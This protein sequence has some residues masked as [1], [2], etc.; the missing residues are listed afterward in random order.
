MLDGNIKD[1]IKE[2]IKNLEEN[3]YHSRAGTDIKKLISTEDPAL[4]RLRIG[5]Y[6]VL[7]FIIQ[8]EVK[9]TKIFH[10]GKGYK[11]LN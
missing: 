1:R 5:D 9:I 7:Y 4:Y 10:R 2:G 11:W 3:P 6:R 8:D